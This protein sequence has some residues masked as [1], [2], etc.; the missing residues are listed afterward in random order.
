MGDL[1]HFKSVNDTYGHDA[2][3]KVLEGFAQILKANIRQSDNCGRLGGEEFLLVMTHLEAD[4]LR[5]VVERIRQQLAVQRFN[6]PNE[7]FV[8]TA[9]FGA[10]LAG[11]PPH[12]RR[13]LMQADT[14]LYA[15]KR[16]GRNCMEIAT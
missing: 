3:D 10:A 15:A 6:S 7:S 2:G 14:A 8:V 4:G 11:E 12:P 16:S 1:D 5:L 9:S 13:L